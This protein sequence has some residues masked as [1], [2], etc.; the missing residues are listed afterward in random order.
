MKKKLLTFSLAAIFGF[1]ATD[2]APAES[3]A[4]SYTNSIG[5][6]F[7]LIPSGSFM[8]ESAQPFEEITENETLQH[9]VSVS[10]PFYLGKYEVTQEQWE[11]VMGS[12]PGKF[13]GRR[14]PAE[15]ISWDDTQA[16]I[17]RL[18]AKEGH[19]R[20]RLPTEAEWEYAARGDTNTLFFFMKNPKTWDEAA[21]QL[22][23]YAW[24]DRNSV[25]TTHPVGTKKPNPFGLYDVYGNV[26]EWVQNRYGARDRVIRGG[27]FYNDAE[28]CRSAARDHLPPDFRHVYLGFRLALSPK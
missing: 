11:A 18:N 25:R 4:K 26:W 7:I 12:N 23:A 2:Y 20:Y 8:K 9:Q 21:R 28:S 10:K 24:F 17:H 22:D 14:N 5:M 1:T 6:A 27:G 13:K 3:G 15:N 16:F 19:T